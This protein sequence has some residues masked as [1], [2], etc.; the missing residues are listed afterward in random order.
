MNLIKDDDLGGHLIESVTAAH[1]TDPKLI[2]DHVNPATI[3]FYSVAT[4]NFCN[5]ISFSWWIILKEA[6]QITGDKNSFEISHTLNKKRVSNHRT[7]EICSAEMRSVMSVA[8]DVLQIL[9]TCNRN[10]F[11]LQMMIYITNLFTLSKFT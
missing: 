2:S 6:N 10:M 5:Q 1:F 7:A 9:L 11:H 3:K 8:D 4:Q